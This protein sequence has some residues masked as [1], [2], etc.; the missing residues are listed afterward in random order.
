MEVEQDTEDKPRWLNLKLKVFEKW[1]RKKMER[2]QAIM[3]GK[4]Y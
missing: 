2:K 1:T 4:N 3:K